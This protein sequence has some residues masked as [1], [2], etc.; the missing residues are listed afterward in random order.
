MKKSSF[1]FLALLLLFAAIHF[2]SFSST[3]TSFEK[4]AQNIR[5]NYH[6]DLELLGEAVDQLHAKVVR[7]ENT[8]A[9]TEALQAAHL[10][11][12]NTFKRIELLLEYY[13]HASIKNYFNGAPLP[14]LMPKVPEIVIL[15]PEGLQ[16][17]DELVFS[18][19]PFEEKK[20][21]IPLVK[22]L[23]LQY[24]RIKTYQQSI[25][26][27]HRHGFEAARKELIRIYTLGVTGFD[28]P[29]SVNAIP[30]AIYAL[31]GT[32]KVIA[33]YY[34]LLKERDADLQL[35]LYEH[36]DSAIKYLEQN[37][38]FD[39]FDRLHF[40]KTFIN[41][42]YGQLYDAQ[43][44]LQIE[45]I[46]E[47]TDR[48]QA[49]NYHSKNIFADNFLNANFF[50][51]INPGDL[52]PERVELGRLL[53]FDPIL[54]ADNKMACASCHQPDLAFTD[55]RPKSIATRGEVN[56]NSPTLVNAVYANRWFYDMRLDQLE[57]QIQHVV[58]NKKEFNTNFQDIVHKLKQSKAYRQRFEAAY[59]DH[60]QYAL[61]PWAVSN[62][63]TAYIVSL[64]SFNSPFDKYV[65]GEADQLPAAA[66][67]GFNLFMGK[68]ACGTCHF[69]PTFYGTVPP[70]FDDSESE[71]LGIPLTTDTLQPVLDPDLGRYR[72]GRPGERVDFYKFGFKTT[73]V[74]NAALTAP[75]MHN[76]VYQSLEEV[77]RFYNRG[78][79]A[80]MGLEL[81]HQT[82]PF[83]ELKLKEQEIND[84]VAF[85]ETLTD[86]PGEDH[87][88][89]ELPKFE[90]KM[91]WNERKIGGAY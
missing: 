91:D 80:G 50:A 49:V 75:Y 27:N 51:N 26:Y 57:Q 69:A 43:K 47:V 70:N 73:T 64:R 71:V 84:I 25:P 42:L 58:F 38:D 13:D 66:K 28:T 33:P 81:E 21:L 60:K 22:S 82:L 40:L 63:I 8:P 74:R 32:R 85:M 31:K 53:F 77:V 76:G 3:V 24:Q 79:G 59:A 41:P 2:S 36:F 55:G 46:D 4:I 89:K 88:P 19:A 29:G 78:G 45:M 35:R 17:I 20:A 54:S 37:N 62:A 15:E 72:N 9:H 16:V 83:S 34:P 87:R 56:R 18:E 39:T 90:D 65:R 11:C 52:T 48:T 12:R 6:Q 5:N 86:V 61:S 67:R 23:K 68:A 14:S 30:E 7:L 10:N 44:I 1:A